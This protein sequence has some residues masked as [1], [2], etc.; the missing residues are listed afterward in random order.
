MTSNAPVLSVVSPAA[1]EVWISKAGTESTSPVLEHFVQGTWT[2]TPMPD[3]GAGTLSA[4]ASND[5][6]LAGTTSLHHYDGAS[7]QPVANPEG[8]AGETLYLQS[9]TDVPGPGAYAAFDYVGVD[10]NDFAST[11]AYYNGSTWSLLGAPILDEPIQLVE[12]MAFVDNT[13]VVLGVGDRGLSQ[14]VFSYA[15]QTW[16]EPVQTGREFCCADLRWAYDWVVDSPTDIWLYGAYSDEN[17]QGPWCGHLTG[18]TLSSGSCVDGTGSAITAATKLAD[19]RHLVGSDQFN[20][21][22]QPDTESVV[23]STTGDFTVIDLTS[24][25]GS[26][27]V[28]AATRSITSPGTYEIQRYGSPT[29]K[30]GPCSKP[31]SRACH[32]T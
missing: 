23:P 30:R 10:A 8:P 17:T 21:L 7:W 13:L 31:R 20:L 14:Y 4:T 5:V 9:V 11:F 19:G 16:S 6:W 3:I 27:V 28:W 22:D 2:Q 26:N 15:A 1:D 12:K 32:R 24:E 29:K 18:A 25:P